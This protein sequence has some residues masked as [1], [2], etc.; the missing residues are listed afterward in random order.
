MPNLLEAFADSLSEADR[1]LLRSSIPFAL[2]VVAMADSEVDKKELAVGE[3]F[4]AAAAERLGAG[5]DAPLSDFPE[6][7]GA[8]RDES[9]P[10][11][12]YVRKLSDLLATVPT[13]AKRLFDAFVIEAALSVA[14]ASGGFLGLGAKMSDH[15]RY[16]IRR[17]LTAY[18]IEV[19]DAA[20]RTL[21]QYAAPM[22]K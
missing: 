6:A 20:Q 2:T 10:S 11:S 13:D 17:L 3:R 8:T 9:W 22:P 19:A 5:F 4:R 21:L 1:A 16:S 15:E 7:L 12:D 14:G 18:R